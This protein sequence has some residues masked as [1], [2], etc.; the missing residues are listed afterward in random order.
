MNQN[1]HIVVLGN[2]KGGSGKS[3]T[4]M[5]LAI[6]LLYMGYRVATID[7][8]AR[9]GSL[10]RYLAN[11]FEYIASSKL[12]LPSPTHVPVDKS[13]ADTLHARETE[14]RENLCMIIDEI[15]LHHDFVIFDTPG[16]ESYLSLVAHAMAKTV[17]TPLNDSFVD[18]D[19]IA[20]V[21][22]QTRDIK[23]PSIYSRIV[24]QTREFR[25]SLRWIVMRN[26]LSSLGSKNKSEMASIL[27]EL[28][29]QFRFELG[30]GFTERVVFRELFLQGLTLLDLSHKTGHSLTMSELTARQEVRSLLSLLLEG[31]K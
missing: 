30:D 22:S 26:R 23:G 25:P 10:T 31:Q 9:Q 1:A 15:K 24:Q 8:D 3:T 18:L 29:T 19:V 21:D 28:S 5:H 4:A 11:R 20:R 16:S 14:D 7:L 17:I 12:D 2:E 13:Y 6:G 27:R